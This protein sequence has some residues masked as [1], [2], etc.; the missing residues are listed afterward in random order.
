MQQ[1]GLKSFRIAAE[2]YGRLEEGRFNGVATEA[3]RKEFYKLM[4]ANDDEDEKK[5]QERRKKAFQR[6]QEK[7]ISIEY[8][9][10]SDDGKTYFPAGPLAGVDEQIFATRLMG[11]RVS[12]K[13]ED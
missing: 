9:R 8:V 1:I 5:Q 4:P 10:P 11:I 6:I 7:L 12:Y 2:T 3:W 13:N